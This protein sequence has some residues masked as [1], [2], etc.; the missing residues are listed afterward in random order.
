MI[1][2][3]TLLEIANPD[4]KVQYLFGMFKAHVVA[5]KKLCDIAGAL[6]CTVC[7]VFHNLNC[8][9]IKNLSSKEVMFPS[10]E[11]PLNC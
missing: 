1:V 11:V 9:S 3:E 8:T 6:K 7:V 5:D 10:I 2:S 4:I